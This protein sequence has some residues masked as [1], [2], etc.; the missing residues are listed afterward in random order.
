MNNRSDG[1]SNLDEILAEIESHENALDDLL[2]ELE[3][4]DQAEEQLNEI[5]D[6]ADS[7][8]NEGTED[9]LAKALKTLS[10]LFEHIEQ[11]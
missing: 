6:T 11:E 1:D 4:I 7:H 9:G 10:A 2:T 3:A 8:L 5:F